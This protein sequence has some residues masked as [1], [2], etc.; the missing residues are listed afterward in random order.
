M[1][2]WVRSEIFIRA[3]STNSEHCH[4][5]LISQRPIRTW[6][7]N[8]IFFYKRIIFFKFHQWGHTQHWRVKSFLVKVY[9]DD[10]LPTFDA[11]CNSAVDLQNMATYIEFVYIPSRRPFSTLLS[12]HDISVSTQMLRSIYQLSGNGELPTI[13]LTAFQEGRVK[14]Y[15]TLMLKASLQSTKLFFSDTSVCIREI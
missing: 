12:C 5:K 10:D 3:I 13:Q 11:S 6:Q 1:V 15:E 8:I 4:I 7:I 2:G 9:C 14:H